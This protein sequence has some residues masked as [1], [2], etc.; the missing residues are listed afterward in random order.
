MFGVAGI[1]LNPIN[2]K[3]SIF[4]QGAVAFLEPK[5]DINV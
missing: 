3:Q 5:T 2:D 4:S 1:G